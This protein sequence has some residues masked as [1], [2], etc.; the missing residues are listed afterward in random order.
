M[1]PSQQNEIQNKVFEVV[2]KHQPIAI[3]KIAQLVRKDLGSV[4][5]FGTQPL[6][7]TGKIRLHGKG[8]ASVWCLPD[9]DYVPNSSKTDL[10]VLGKRDATWAD[11][12]NR[13]VAALAAHEL[14]ENGRQGARM[15]DLEDATGLKQPEIRATLARLIEADEVDTTGERRAMRYFLFKPKCVPL[16]FIPRG[17]TCFAPVSVET[18]DAAAVNS[19]SDACAQDDLPPPPAV[20]VSP[21]VEDLSEFVA[22]PV[23]CDEDDDT[24]PLDTEDDFSDADTLKL[25]DDDLAALPSSFDYDYMPPTV[26]D[27]Q[28]LEALAGE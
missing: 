3:S 24:A 12:R 27:W 19:S 26:D 22:V 14:T 4:R 7:L 13:I 8:K 20:M 1:T 25:S 28:E 11:R 15:S 5:R 18:T 10:N 2:S 16:G 23:E 17:F 6:A 21:L 9:F